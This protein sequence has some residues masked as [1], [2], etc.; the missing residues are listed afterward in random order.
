MMFLQ[1]FKTSLRFLGVLFLR[2]LLGIVVGYLWMFAVAFIFHT[3]A[4]NPPESPPVGSR[5]HLSIFQIFD[6]FYDAGPPRDG[7]YRGTAGEA[8]PTALQIGLIGFYVWLAVGVLWGFLQG[9]LDLR[10]WLRRRHA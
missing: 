9:R 2:V 1:K 8:Y 4:G 6:H 3:A 5:G 7:R 10:R